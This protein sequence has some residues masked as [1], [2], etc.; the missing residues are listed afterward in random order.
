MHYNIITCSIVQVVEIPESIVH[1]K[2]I[3]EVVIKV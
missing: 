3:I 1:T 2:I